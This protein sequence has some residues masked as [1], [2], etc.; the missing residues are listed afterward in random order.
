MRIV[1]ILLVSSLMTLPVAAGIR[2]A[3]GFKQ[4]IIYSVVFGEISVVG[5][6]VLA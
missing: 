5:G 1:G 2:L 6:L 4:L 3:K